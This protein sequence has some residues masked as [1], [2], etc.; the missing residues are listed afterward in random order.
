MERVHFD[1]NVN[2]EFYK[3]KDIRNRTYGED[4]RKHVC[5]SQNLAAASLV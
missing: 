3:G 1:E 5:P 2:Y 4:I